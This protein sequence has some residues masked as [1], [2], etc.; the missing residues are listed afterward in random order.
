M[1]S[2]GVKEKT[3]PSPEEYLKQ[4]PILGG[5]LY[6]PGSFVDAGPMKLFHQ[7]GGLRRFIH[8][9]YRPHTSQ[10]TYQRT[11]EG[12]F[13]ASPETT[14]IG[15]EKFRAR[16]WKDL[17]H[18]QVGERWEDEA[19]RSFGFKQEF[20]FEGPKKHVDFT[21]MFVD[22][23]GAWKFLIRAGSLPD[24]VVL[25]DHGFGGNWA[26]QDGFGGTGQLYQEVEKVGHWPEH[27]LVAD[28][29]RPWPGYQPVS[30]ATYQ[31]GQMHGHRRAIWRKEQKP[32]RPT[33]PGK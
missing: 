31:K 27:L 18:A 19:E 1:S 32:D 8:V 21:F 6:Y 26:T 14:P 33:F 15:P 16:R 2:R 23:I 12:V 29:T 9:D 20:R 28:N 30:Q 4:N 5:L 24:V 10:G 17:W 11:T 22:A 25:H 13:D 3:L 7:F